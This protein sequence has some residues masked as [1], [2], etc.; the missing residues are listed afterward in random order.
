MDK[1]L[2]IW[3]FSHLWTFRFFANVDFSKTLVRSFMIP[4]GLRW[5]LCAW[6]SGFSKWLKD[7]SVSN[8]REIVQESVGL[9]LVHHSHQQPA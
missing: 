2:F 8:W 4:L 6:R 9:C 7:G 5:R 3:P 1:L